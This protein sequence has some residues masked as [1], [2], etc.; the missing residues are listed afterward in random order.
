M[1]DDL[2]SGQSYTPAMADMK[3]KSTA[4][5][6]NMIFIVD[7][8]GSMR[9]E[10]RIEAVNEAFREM[11]PSLVQIQEESLSEFELRLSIMRFHEI[12]E[13]HVESVPILEYHHKDI[14]CTE[15]VTFYSNA[16]KTLN[17]KLTRKEFMAG[18]GKKAQPYIMFLT[19]GEPTPEDDYDEALEELKKNDWFGASQR[20]AV[21]I[22]KDTINS[23]SARTAVEKFVSNPVECIINAADAQAIVSEVQARTLHTIAIATKHGVNVPVEDEKDK[24]S[25]DAVKDENEDVFG[26][27]FD[28]GGGSF[29]Y[30]EI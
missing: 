19:D 21:L 28:N 22:G 23:E 24:V 9:F 26:S 10:G 18:L 15:W 17:E 20:Y 6:L 2:M 5:V 30:D 25:N 3:I 27:F 16:F 7:V 4:K 13:W 12:S 1:I 29:D 11:I 14:E 8:S